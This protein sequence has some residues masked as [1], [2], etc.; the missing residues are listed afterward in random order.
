MPPT[1]DVPSAEIATV[2]V[3][4]RLAEIGRRLRHWR[5]NEESAAAT[6]AISITTTPFETRELVLAALL[7]LAGVPRRSWSQPLA[8]PGRDIVAA[9]PR[10]AFLQLVDRE[11]TYLSNV[12]V[13]TPMARI[14][15][16]L[17]RRGVIDRLVAMTPER[18]A[19]AVAEETLA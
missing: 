11:R 10:A 19:E 1:V 16:T 6:L 14:A 5:K 17:T 4:E 12:P 15:R 9:E 18:I 3:A 8:A 13:H 2:A 7:A